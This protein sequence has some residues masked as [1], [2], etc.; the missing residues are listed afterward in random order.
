M[1][2]PL[3]PSFSSL[4]ERL[5][6]ETRP[7]HE[8]IEAVLDLMDEGLTMSAYRSRLERFYGFYATIERRLHELG[9]WDEHGIDLSARRKLPLLESDLKALGVEAVSG[10]PVCMELPI[11]PGLADGFG[12]LYVLEGSTL[13]GQFI[14]RH[15]REVLGVTPEAGGRFFHGYGEETGSMWRSF[16]VAL[17]DFAD[18]QVIQDRVVTAAFA[19]FRGLR[20]WFEG[21]AAV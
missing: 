20:L 6:N 3:A 21:V 1:R 15:V 7:E 4:L 2:A 17:A 8:A 5:K 9:G 10:L 13:G 14:G 16:R 19:T 18:T 12:C 11:L